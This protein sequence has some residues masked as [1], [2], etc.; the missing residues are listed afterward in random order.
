MKFEQQKSIIPNFT[1]IYNRLKNNG[2]EFPEYKG[3][4]YNIY[5]QNK[6]NDNNDDIND[7]FYYFVYLKDILKEQNFQ[8]KYRRLVAYLLKMNENIKL[9]NIYID[10][11]ETNKLEEVIKILNEGNNI[12]KENI[13]G[14][15]LK[16]E[17]LMEFALAKNE[18]IK[19]TISRE[20]DFNKGISDINKFVSSFEKNNII[21]RNNMNKDE[22]F[23]KL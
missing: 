17:K 16:D 22:D 18:D 23:N 7:S 3:D 19:N 1:D 10:L 12:L 8:H 9:A 13:I 11:K 4:D 20:E 2:V 14:G 21:P 5:F 6:N 15:R